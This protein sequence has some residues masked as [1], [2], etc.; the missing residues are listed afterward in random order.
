MHMH[1]GINQEGARNLQRW[2]GI[3]IGFSVVTKGRK[4]C[5]RRMT[6]SGKYAPTENPQ[7]EI[8]ANGKP[9]EG[10]CALFEYVHDACVYP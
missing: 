7:E 9:R 10:M 5:G 3:S 1:E 4:H 8:C 2:P 6:P